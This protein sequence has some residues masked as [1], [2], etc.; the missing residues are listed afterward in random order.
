MSDAE[1]QSAIRLASQWIASRQTV[2]PKRL[3]APGPNAA[4]L[5]QLFQAAAAAPDHDL[6]NPWR[7]LIIPAHKRADLGDR[8]AAA[9]LERDANASTD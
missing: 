5:E 7:F 8:F 1:K 6:I 2:L 4:E 9:L 3:V